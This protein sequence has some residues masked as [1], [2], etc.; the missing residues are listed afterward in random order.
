MKKSG[1]KKVAQEKQVSGAGGVTPQPERHTEGESSETKKQPWLVPDYPELEGQVGRAAVN[2]QIITYPSVIRSNNDKPIPQQSFGNFS[3]MFF[4]EPRRLKSGKPVYGFFKARGNWPDAACAQ[5]EATQ[6]VKKQDSKYKVRVGQVGA[7]LPIVDDDAVVENTIDVHD[8]VNKAKE[9]AV[10][11]TEAERERI[12]RE[13]RE[14][15]DEVKNAKDYHDDKDSIDY[16]TMKRVAWRQMN[17]TIQMEMNKIEKLR[18]KT[19]EVREALRELDKKHPE[20]AGAWLDNYN[21]AL[22]KVGVKD[23]VP[24]EREQTLYET[25]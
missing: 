18:E 23:Y 15:E 25:S 9:D 11:E 17:E 22:R 5:N 12:M 6:I 10:K 20:H 3:F 7:W 4:K 16:Y 14:R 13:L 24:S 1:S 19:K 2:G 21:A 8:Q